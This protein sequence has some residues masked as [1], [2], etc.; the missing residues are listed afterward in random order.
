MFLCL[1]VTNEASTKRRL[2]YRFNVGL[3]CC[4]AIA[5]GMAALWAFVNNDWSYQ[6]NSLVAGLLAEPAAD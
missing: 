2:R 1:Q 3:M 4:V 5:G 6:A